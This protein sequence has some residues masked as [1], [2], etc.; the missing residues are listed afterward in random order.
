MTPDE[1]RAM[2]AKIASGPDGAAEVVSGLMEAGQPLAALFVTAR[3]TAVGVVGHVEAL[4]EAVEAKVGAGELDPVVAGT[5]V[6]AAAMVR[7]EIATHISAG[8]R[9]WMGIPAGYTYGLAYR[10]PPDPRVGAAWS[11]AGWARLFT[12]TDADADPPTFQI[13]QVVRLMRHVPTEARVLGALEADLL[14]Y[15]YLLAVAI[16]SAKFHNWNVSDEFVRG[17]AA[18]IERSRP[19]QHTL[20]VLVLPPIVI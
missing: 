2:L 14:D 18:A 3:P 10:P 19:A 1:L 11:A 8:S 20:V 4:V 16:R 15:P 9:L 12:D 6:W 5:V 17:F 7:P 13:K